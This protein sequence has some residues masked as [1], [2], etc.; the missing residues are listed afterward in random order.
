MKRSVRKYILA[1]I[2]IV[3]LLAPLVA[4]CAQDEVQAQVAESKLTRDT[5]P[6]VGATD[7]DKFKKRAP[8]RVN[9]TLSTE[10]PLIY[11]S[12]LGM[13]FLPFLGRK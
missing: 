6:D 11:A 7:L 12:P 2:L 3:T 5:S 13:S 8:L 10:T 4:G 9:G 1:S